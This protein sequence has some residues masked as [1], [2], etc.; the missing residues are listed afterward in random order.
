MKNIRK[1]LW[2][3]CV[4]GLVAANIAMWPHVS[5][6]GQARVAF[7]DVGQGDA[8]L[9]KTRQGHR[10]L[11]DGGPNNKVV[12]KVGQALPFWD[13]TI[14]LMVLTHADA[15]HITG[16]VDVLR[17][18]EVKNVLWNGIEKE[19]NVFALWKEAVE[20]ETSNVWLAD[21]TQKIVWSQ[22]TNEYVD[23]LFASKQAKEINDTSVITKLYYGNHSFLFSGDISKAIEQEMVNKDISLEATVLKVPHHGSKSSGSANF[24]SAV[25][26]DIAVIQ[27]GANNRYGHPAQEV[28]S[29]LSAV[30][31]AVLRTDQKGDIIFQTNGNSFEFSHN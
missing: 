21:S 10:I 18:F 7:F 27:V 17:Q 28:L 5:E 19:T 16:L 29:R 9:I 6:N 2:Y 14:D 26:S 25:H 4:A 20:A 1:K 23:V 13:K 15:D 30:G 3:G 12:E 31:T 24:L 8:I 11:I 22:D